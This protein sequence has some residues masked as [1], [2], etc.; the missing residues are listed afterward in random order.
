[1]NDVKFWRCVSLLMVVVLM[2]LPQYCRKVETVTD[3]I[4]IPS[5]ESEF[6]WLTPE[7]KK[8]I[9]YIYSDEKDTILLENPINKE[10][11]A[12]YKE[13][14]R[15]NDS[16]ALKLLYLNAIQ[17]RTYNKTFEDK[18]ITINATAHT[19]GTLD[20]LRIHYKTKEDTIRLKQK[21]F[22]LK[23]GPSIGTNVENLSLKP[24]F[25]LGLENKKGDLITIDVN[26]SKDV[27]I[28]Y[29]FNIFEYKK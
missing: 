1:M 3:Y 7:A 24:G 6:E 25:T 18:N 27:K 28:G 11:E 15:K 2:L 29:L 13:A 9:E 19:T 21:V 23:A 10:L 5:K 8:G 16:M 14:L 12:K 22:A 20:S 17:T 4:V 26:T